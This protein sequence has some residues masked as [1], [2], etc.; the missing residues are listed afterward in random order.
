MKTSPDTFCK[1]SSEEVLSRF[2]LLKDV[3]EP[4]FIFINLDLAH[5]S[6]HP[7]SGAASVAGGLLGKVLSCC[8]GLPGERGDARACVCIIFLLFI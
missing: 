4:H 1:L 8:R 5:I 3:L 6:A 2:S 7:R